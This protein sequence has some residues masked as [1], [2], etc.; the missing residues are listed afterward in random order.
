M[1]VSSNFISSFNY[2]KGKVF[3]TMEKKTLNLHVFQNLAFTT[4]VFAKSLDV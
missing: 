4:I 1:L 3:P 2:F